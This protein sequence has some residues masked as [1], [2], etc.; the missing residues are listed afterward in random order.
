MN[1]WKCHESYEGKERKSYLAHRF[2]V[3]PQGVAS[4]GGDVGLP[5]RRLKSHSKIYNFFENDTS[6]FTGPSNIYPE[7][8]TTI[9]NFNQ[10]CEI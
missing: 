10:V 9:Q 3:P 2:H 7:A 8:V 1:T 6:K 5:F 4:I